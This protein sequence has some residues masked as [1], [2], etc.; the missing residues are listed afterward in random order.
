M[1]KRPVHG[2]LL[3]NKPVGISAN[4]AL[5]KVKR[6]F[7]AK[8]AGHT[9]TLDK[10]ASGLLPICFGEATK[11]ANF[12]LAEDKHYQVE[13]ML[14]MSTTTGD[15]EGEIIERCPVEKDTETRL[16][17]ILP[18]FI[19]AIQ[20]IPP[21]YSALKYQGQA[22]YTLA[23][24][25]KTVERT[26]R[27]VV[28]HTLTIRDFRENRLSL[29]VHCSKGTYIR[30]LV[31]DIGQQLGCGAYVQ[32]LHRTQVGDYQTMIDFKTLADSAERGLAH[33]DQL[34][35][36]VHTALKQYPAITLSTTHLMHLRQG[37][38]IP[39][40]HSL[41]QGFVKL[42]IANEEIPPYFFGIGQVL[43]DGRIAPKRL[44]NI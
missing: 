34:L 40:S 37:R 41:T 27:T 23:R 1:I 2:I 13:C 3:F 36:P 43:T 38:A 16:T 20:Q 17:Q 30:T 25:G 35:L 10:L 15:A 11:F 9:G 26:P 5:Q 33:L 28:I 44:L 32:A 12:L 21:M 42:F 39:F 6:L 24:Q 7:Q 4:G 22:L 8:K 18:T 29:T 31:A 19:G 14:G